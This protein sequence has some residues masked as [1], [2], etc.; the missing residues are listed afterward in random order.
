MSS[1]GYYHEIKYLVLMGRLTYCVNQVN[2]KGLSINGI[3]HEKVKLYL[4]PCPVHPTSIRLRDHV[5][6]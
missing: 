3:D 6:R 4:N 5:K 2:I 1:E